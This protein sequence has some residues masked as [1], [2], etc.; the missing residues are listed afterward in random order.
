MEIQV[1]QNYKIK[2]SILFIFLFLTL[3]IFILK[4]SRPLDPGCSQLTIAW[5]LNLQLSTGQ[6]QTIQANY[7]LLP[8]GGGR[9]VLGGSRLGWGSRQWLEASAPNTGPNRCG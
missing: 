3:L 2:L 5:S 1:Y 4:G 7:S 6:P 8:P 9:P